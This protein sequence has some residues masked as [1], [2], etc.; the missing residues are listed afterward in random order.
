MFQQGERFGQIVQNR[1]RSCPVLDR[2][3]EFAKLRDVAG[4]S[5]EDA[6]MRLHVTA[7]SIRRYETFGPRGSLPSPLAMSLMENFAK[8]N[9]R[10]G[11]KPASGF[12]FIDLFAGIGRLRRGFLDVGG[13]CVFSSE[14]NKF[15]QE[16]Y[17]RNFR[18]NHPIFGDIT[19]LENPHE[20]PDHDVHLA[21]F[22]CQPFS[23]AVSPC[24]SLD[25][26]AT[27]QGVLQIFG[28]F[29]AWARG[30]SV[31]RKPWT[32]L[33]T[34]LA[35]YL[36]FQ[37]T[38][39]QID[40]RN[41]QIINLAERMGRTP[42]SLAMKLA[43]I[44]SL[45]PKIRE[46]GRTGLT[47]ATQL[48]RRIWDA[49]HADWTSLVIEVEIFLGNDKE[50]NANET[51]R[52]PRKNYS[53]ERYEENSISHSLVETRL[54]QQFFRRAVLV[55]FDMKCCVT[56]IAEPSLLNA[57]HIL[58]WH[59]DVKNRHNPANGLCFSATFD[60]AFDRG[61]MTVDRNQC[62]KISNILLHHIDYSTREYFRV[63]A[64]VKIHTPIRF[65][66]DSIF[67]DYHNSNIFVG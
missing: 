66:P 65:E 2:R 60:R 30:Q 10:P 23:I 42:S 63:Y 61:L 8:A 12:R 16:T 37:L 58:P 31:T 34:K 26:S 28:H 48:D 7:R 46:T 22:P 36:Y 54:G 32:E 50:I 52:E 64:G 41:P 18:D 35:L 3:T 55:N 56:G 62:V 67:I 5:I 4:L 47:G 15:A 39:G 53:A 51:L 19:T 45:D 29:L 25:E 9:H 6:A 43:N 13:H 14:Y 11:S 57:S 27:H 1:P 24:S 20:A 17:A 59:A 33:D 49:F 38:F 21:G 40:S 44:A